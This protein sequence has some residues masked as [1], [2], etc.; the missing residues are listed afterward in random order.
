MRGVQRNGEER[1]GEERV[2][3]DYILRPRTDNARTRLPISSSVSLDLSDAEELTQSS[4]TCPSRRRTTSVRSGSTPQASSVPAL[5]L[6]PPPARAKKGESRWRHQRSSSDMN[7]SSSC[8]QSRVS[9][10]RSS[11]KRRSAPLPRS[12]LRSAGSRPCSEGCHRY[13][14]IP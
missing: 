7:S 3:E 12:P 8:P 13:L 11:E 1:E 2:K 9:S 10:V 4:I 14:R 6:P 5:P